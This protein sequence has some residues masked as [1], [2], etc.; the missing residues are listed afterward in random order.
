MID[1]QDFIMGFCV[2]IIYIA[3]VFIVTRL[4]KQSNRTSMRE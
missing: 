2:G 1:F 3:V 4:I